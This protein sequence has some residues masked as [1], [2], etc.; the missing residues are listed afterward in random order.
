VCAALEEAN[1][2]EYPEGHGGGER[3]KA[4]GIEDQCADQDL[5]AAADPI[6]DKRGT[7]VYRKRITGVLTRRAAGIAYERAR[8]R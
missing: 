6:D 7:A 1:R 5:L 4:Q 2:H 3:E 8:N